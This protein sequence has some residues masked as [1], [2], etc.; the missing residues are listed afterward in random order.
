MKA[1]GLECTLK[2]LDPTYMIRTVPAN[3][4]DRILCTMLAN[5]TVHGAFAGF[6]NFS[7]GIVAG[8]T[9]YIPIELLT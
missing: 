2:Y 3:S 8:K 6:T 4:S 9:V 5:A 7:T 1:R